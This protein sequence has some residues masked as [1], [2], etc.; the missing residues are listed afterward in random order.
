LGAWETKTKTD[1]YFRKKVLW[2]FLFSKWKYLPILYQEMYWSRTHAGIFKF[3][4]TTAAVAS[5]FG[6]KWSENENEMWTLGSKIPFAIKTLSNVIFWYP[7]KTM[8]E[9]FA[10]QKCSMKLGRNIFLTFIL[11]AQDVT[12]TIWYSR[13]TAQWILHIVLFDAIFSLISFYLL[14]NTVQITWFSEDTYWSLILSQKLHADFIGCLCRSRIVRN[15][16]VTTGS[17]TKRLKATRQLML[18]LSR[19]KN[20]IIFII[21]IIL[22]LTTL[23]F[24][25]RTFMQPKSPCRNSLLR[26]VKFINAASTVLGTSSNQIRNFEH[27]LCNRDCC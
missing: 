14:V 6:L 25:H 27:L 3:T 20:I 8:E 21:I 18:R 19:W 1:E 26:C 2:N 16:A 12:W 11:R 5:P 15:F 17:K 13:P 10:R 9:L 24:C 23:H 7:S 4:F 22:D